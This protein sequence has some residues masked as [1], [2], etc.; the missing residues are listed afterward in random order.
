MFIRKVII[1]IKRLIFS[2]CRDCKF[3]ARF[4]FLR[5]G[6]SLFGRVGIKSIA[7]KLVTK[8][9]NWLYSYL[10]NEL[11]SVTEK[12]K[13]ESSTGKQ[14]ENSPIWVCWWTG[15]DSAPALVKK[16]V[17]STVNN[18]GDHPV[19]ILTQDNIG[20]YIDIPPHMTDKVKSGQM[21]L[22]HLADYLRVKLLSIYGGL[23][24]DA[25]MFC[26]DMVPELCFDLP[27]Y[28]CKGPVRKSNYVSDYRWVTFCLGGWKGNVFYRYLAEALETY[29][30]NNSTAIDYLFFD[31]VILRGYSCIPAIKLF[32]DN[33][34]DNNIH[35]DDLQAA[36][37]AALPASQ[38][39]SVIQSD[40]VLYKLSWRESY[41]M[42]SQN[43]EE[44]VYAHFIK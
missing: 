21:G 43:G 31:Y 20:E 4:A 44:S 1:F 10:S 8:R 23:W 11:I 35:R 37:N 39:D 36:M 17:L 27:V 34:P 41:S 7:N 12:Y 42:L 13:N 28:T 3:S 33:V 18:A 6:E 25:T 38:F 5:L 40:T 15:L 29:W 16:C 14:T 19:H 9:Q 26:S 24:L 2:F 32:L 30:R 22:A